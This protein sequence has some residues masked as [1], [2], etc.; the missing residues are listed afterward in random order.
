MSESDPNTWPRQPLRTRVASWLLNPHGAPSLSRLRAAVGG[1]TVL[2]TGV[3]FGIG[4]AA[5]RLLASAGAKVLLAARSQDQLDT[6]AAIIRS[7]GGT[8]EVCRV[9]LTDTDAVAD[10]AQRLLDAHG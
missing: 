9:D 7:Q 10:L 8:A 6:I 4:E 5:A 2:I 1:K 3:S